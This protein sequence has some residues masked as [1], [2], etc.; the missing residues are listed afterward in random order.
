[1]KKLPTALEISQ[2]RE[3]FIALSL[4]LSR[5]PLRDVIYL[6]RSLPHIQG[7][8][9]LSEGNKKKPS[10]THTVYTEPSVKYKNKKYT[11]NH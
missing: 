7:R 11:E 4:S 6:S 8:V 10:T 2:T 3:G 5:A 9:L 1:M